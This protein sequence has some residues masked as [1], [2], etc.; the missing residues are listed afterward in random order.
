MGVPIAI[1]LLL[2]LILWGFWLIW[3]KYHNRSPRRR[4]SGGSGK[5][6]IEGFF[7]SLGGSDPS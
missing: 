5:G 4:R 3:Q 1:V 2:A 7:D 6:L